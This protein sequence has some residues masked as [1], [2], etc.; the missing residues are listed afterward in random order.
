VADQ[1]GLLENALAKDR[2]AV[3]YGI[4]FDFNSATIKPQSERELQTIAAV[5]K[6]NP[7]WTLN[8]EGH[9]DNIGGDSAN[10]D[11][12]SRRAAAV[13]TALIELG[14]PE[15]SLLTSAFGASV[16][17]ATNSTLAGRARNRRV[18]LTRQ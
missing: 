4:Y 18:E 12:S 13:R 11:L 3:I 14:I 9:T 2:R 8:V 6:K 15:Q 1:A 10:Q 16:P 5:M 7:D 17:R